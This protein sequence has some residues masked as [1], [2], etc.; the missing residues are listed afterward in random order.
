[1]TLLQ[2][3]RPCVDRF[4]SESGWDGFGTNTINLAVTRWMT[5]DIWSPKG[6]DLIYYFFSS[7]GCCIVDVTN[8]FFAYVFFVSIVIFDDL[9]NGTVL[10]NSCSVLNAYL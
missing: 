9:L 6:R 7:V 4:P 3:V 5:W 2:L 8:I 1:M 10:I